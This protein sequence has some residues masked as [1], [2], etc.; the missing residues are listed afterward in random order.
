MSTV[1]DKRIV[2]MDFDN[3]DFE[4]NVK[5]S[6]NTL[7]RLKMSLS[8]LPAAVDF[9]GVASVS[10][11]IQNGLTNSFQNVA[12]NVHSIFARIGNTILTDTVLQWKRGIENIIEEASVR[13][14]AA[15]WNKYAKNKISTNYY[16]CY[17]TSWRL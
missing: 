1:V 10:D 7:D 15:G 9:G 5:T 16:G 2:E 3:D 6:L 11:S 8:G 14:L 17:K 12:N 13:Q 4:S